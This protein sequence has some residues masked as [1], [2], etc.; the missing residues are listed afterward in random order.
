MK[1]MRLILNYDRLENE[2]VQNKNTEQKLD[3]E[4]E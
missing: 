3:S 2:I 1:K 4:K